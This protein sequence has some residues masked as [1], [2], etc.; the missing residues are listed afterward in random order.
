MLKIMLKH[1]EITQKKGGPENPK[2]RRHTAHLKKKMHVFFPHITS[3]CGVLFF[4]WQ[5][6]VDTE[7]R[8]LEKNLRFI[9]TL[10]T[11]KKT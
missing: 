6:G 1:V 7:K 8:L 3:L 4:C 10:H 11:G 5:S 2:A 9:P